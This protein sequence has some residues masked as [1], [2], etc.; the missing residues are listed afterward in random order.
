MVIAIAIVGAFA[1]ISLSDSNTGNNYGSDESNNGFNLGTESSTVTSSSISLSEVYGLALALNSKAQSQDLSTISSVEYKGVTFTKEQCLYIFSK[2]ID[3]KNRGVTG[4][5]EFRYYSSAD[6]P[7][8]SYITSYLTKSEYVDMAQ[9]THSWMDANGRAP[10]YT[11]VYIAGSPDFGSDYLLK[12]FTQVI[13]NSN[14]ES[15]VSMVTL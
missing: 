14:D 3:M 1:F 15:L 10:N 5:I 11:G 2:A 13:I 6:S 7:L 8:N 12:V 4:D 9:R